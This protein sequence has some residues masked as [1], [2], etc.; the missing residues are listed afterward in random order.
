MAKNQ[1]AKPRVKRT[2]S[3]AR[4]ALDYAQQAARLGYRNHDQDDLDAISDEAVEAKFV[5]GQDPVIETAKG[6]RLPTVPVDEALKLNDLKDHMQGK[7]PSSR[8]PLIAG[9]RE[10]KDGTLHGAL[11]K[12]VHVV[13]E[14]APLREAVPPA[15]TNPLFPPLPV[16]GPPSF[17]RTLQSWF[18]RISSFYLSLGLLGFV[19]LGSAFTSIGPAWRHVKMRLKFQDPNSRRPYYTEEKIRQQKRKEEEHV[20]TQ[21]AGRRKRRKSGADPQEYGEGHSKKFPPLEGGSDPVIPDA[22]YYAR[23]I[24]LDMEEFDVQTEDGFIIQLW[25][26][27]DPKEQKSARPELRQAKSAA[28]FRDD[29][30]QDGRKRG[31]T[32]SQFADGNR[33]YPVLLM[34]GLLQNAGAFCCNDDDSLA[35]FLA[36]SGYDVWLGNNRCGMNP[37]HVLLEYGDPRMWAWN[38]RQMGVMDLPALISRV[39]EETGFPKLGLVAHSQGTTQTF[40]ALAKE[41]RPDIGEKISVFCALAPA[42]YAGRLIEVYFALMRVIPPSL[43]RMIFGIHAFIPL[44]PKAHEWLPGKLYSFLAYRVFSFLFGWNDER[45]ELGLRDRMF[46]FS[47]TFVSAESMRWWLGRECFMRQKCI[48]ATRAEGR[49]EEEEDEEEDDYFNLKPNAQSV[50]ELSCHCT[51]HYHKEHGRYAWYDDR[52]PP[53]AFWIAGR[54]NLVDGRR[55]LRRFERGREPNVNVVHS[56]LIEGYE[57]LD[58]IWSMDAIEK[59]G[60]EVRQVLWRT[61]PQE[62]KKLCRVPTACGEDQQK[63]PAHHTLLDATAGE[64]HEDVHDLPAKV[65]QGS[66]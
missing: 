12:S 4:A 16:Y 36:K 3:R 58:V 63:K 61:A 55:L 41:Q 26:L 7:D 66:I 56:K 49:L 39:L 21:Q 25:H 11:P 65:L 6:E 31:T 5:T 46:Q 10:A 43:F 14:S 44:M 64:W 40:V 32:A 37:K 29:F 30:I 45:W 48:L 62:A 28:V 50:A 57:H 1:P 42:V 35:F 54:D 53:F 13:D 9:T 27:F 60:S 52:A 59:V 20:W 17:I 19:V 51:G 38:I 18:F 15:Y 34:P 24:G 2:D 8:E 47:P 22:A 33:R 23:R